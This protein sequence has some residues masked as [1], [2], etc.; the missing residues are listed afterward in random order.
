MN[1]NGFAPSVDWG[2]ELF[3]SALW[4]LEAFVVAAVCLAVILVLVGRHTE[5]GRQFW[6]LNG[7]YFTTSS[8]RVTVWLM[9]A[10]LLLSAVLSVRIAVLLSYYANDLFSSLQVAFEGSGDPGAARRES[11]V[12]GF[13]QSMRIF[14]VLATVA[15]VRSLVDLYLMQRFAIRWRVW[16]TRRLVDDWLGGYAYYRGQLISTPI[17]NPDQR[18]QQ[19]VDVVTNG[20]GEPNV[21]SHGSGNTL[22]FGAV[23]SV[24]SVA[25][26]GVILWRLSG[27]LTVA[28][29]T[30]PRA[31]FW[32]VIV[33][34][35][36][37]T[38]LAFW[39]GRPLIRLSF[40]N[41][42]RNAS[43]RYAMVRMKEAASAVGLYRGED[44]ER[45][46]L[47][48][49]LDAVVVNYRHWLNRMVA[50]LGFNLSVSQAINPLP[51]IVQAQRL[52]A[53]R[54]SFGDVMQSATAFHAIH[55][56]L[57]FFRNAYDAFASY[58]AAL[59]RLDGLQTANEATRGLPRLTVGR[60]GG[61]GLRLEGVD[62]RTPDGQLL[63][64]ALDARLDPGESVVVTGP[65]GSGKTT[66]L[67]S[68]AGLWPH[69]SGRV[70]FPVAEREVMFV[71]QL[72]Y[73]PLGDLRAVVSYPRPPE[74]VDAAAVQQALVKVALPHLVIR[75]TENKDW[76]RILSVGE[77][78]RVAF[79]RILLHRPR[80]VFLDE[81]TSAMDEGLEVMLYRLLRDELP[82]TI[83]VSVSHR[84]TVEQHHD[85]Q[86][87]LLG[88]GG[89]RL[90][91][92]STST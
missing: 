36:V 61:D 27:P 84:E 7:P 35:L 55:D 42:F 69:A 29:V 19:D 16:L 50:F 13:W 54:I 85:R 11:G 37:A 66:L 82:S 9:L 74:E 57:S 72:P 25:S 63:V 53:G 60:S 15:T 73:I 38:V 1:S 58:R 62:V 80:V 40:L 43:L 41:E 65:S 24:L 23:E 81:S 91:P 86:L 90:D 83:L 18:I 26:F 59:I 46:L 88:A 2:D 20:T 77:Q 45:R 51:Y 49:R 17:D 78:Q 28:D 30:L 8:A 34:V 56:A 22:L 67:E 33:Y 32:I 6:R 52:F 31:L 87:E 5:W 3:A 75:I 44:A 68:L 10:G 79:A 47:T 12:D 48:T 4:V 70:E 71:S 76:A 14:A 21:P 89:W 92:V 39:I 64:E